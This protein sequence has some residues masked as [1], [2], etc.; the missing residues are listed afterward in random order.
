VHIKKAKVTNFKS[1]D[2][3]EEFLVDQVTC[4]VGK[5]E[6]GKTAVLD[7]L[8][9]INPVEANKADFTEFDFPRRRIKRDY[10]GDE[11]KKEEA[12][13]TTWTLDSSDL[14]AATKQFG[15]NPYQSPDVT[16]V[17]GYDNQ[18][19]V[20]ATLNHSAAL[21]HHL[22]SLT[23][24][25]REPANDAATV[26]AAVEALS[27]LASLTEKQKVAV[28]AL[29]KDFPTA[30]PLGSIRK[31]VVGRIPKVIKF[32]EYY[33]LPGRISIN[34]LRQKIQ[35]TQTSF[36]ERVFLALLDLA[37]T[38]I[39]EITNVQKTEQ[40]YMELEA[41]S[42]QLTD[43]IFR[44]WSTNA[45]LSVKFDVRDGKPGDPPPFNSGPVFHT[46]IDNA[47]HR[48]SVEFDERSSGFIWFFSF[49]V[50]FS[51][52]KKNYGNNLLILLDEPGRDLPPISVHVRI[53]QLSSTPSP[54]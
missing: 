35:Q 9:K 33:R 13:R 11:W 54:V 39:D 6:A 38:T 14:D 1:V 37:G 32:S 29:K 46:R 40:L 26:S 25:E 18:L 43:E 44:Y 48:V 20:G 4:L 24:A 7:A 22:G 47:R 5:N 21:T 10:E 41:I 28:E 49:L 50:W 30:D 19:K 12:V 15:F 16:I 45:Q 27:K 2:N 36:N 42:N 23:T 53:R 31:F 3:S 52:V 17:K 34:E 8:Y 51:Q